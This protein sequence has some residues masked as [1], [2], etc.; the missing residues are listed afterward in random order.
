VEWWKICRSSNCN[1]LRCNRWVSGVNGLTG[2]IKYTRETERI[3]RY[4]FRATYSLIRCRDST[5]DNRFDEFCCFFDLS[6]MSLRVT[7]DIASHFSWDQEKIPSFAPVTLLFRYVFPHSSSISVWLF[8]M[9][10][11]VIYGGE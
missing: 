11:P 2:G 10:P 8:A 5:I 4:F 6:Y 1:K 3:Y 7:N 9:H